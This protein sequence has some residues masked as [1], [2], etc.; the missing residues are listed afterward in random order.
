[1]VQ[2]SVIQN[3][4]ECKD[5][6]IIIIIIIIKIPTKFWKARFFVRKGKVAYKY[7]QGYDRLVYVYLHTTITSLLDEIREITKDIESTP[8]QSTHCFQNN[9]EISF[10][11]SH[12]LL[13]ISSFHN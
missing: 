7:L 3:C 12:I 10:L 2:K 5:I 8:L 11:D 1:M 9:H 4:N 13:K 6:I